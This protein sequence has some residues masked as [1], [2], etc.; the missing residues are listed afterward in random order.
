MLYNN[1]A[2]LALDFTEM[3]K[4]KREIAPPQKIRTVDQ[5]SW[6]VLGFQISKALNSIVIDM[7]QE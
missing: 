4:V 5:K 1:E 3:R 2:I 6:L 7:L